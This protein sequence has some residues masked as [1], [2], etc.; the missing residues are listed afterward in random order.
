MEIA[1]FGHGFGTKRAEAWNLNCVAAGDGLGQSIQDKV[2]YLNGCGTF[3][4][5]RAGD[6]AG[7]AMGEF[8][9]MIPA[10]SAAAV[11]IALGWA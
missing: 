8:H 4:L 5:M 10:Q 1:S 2:D 3:Q 11:D 7:K 9:C 6:F